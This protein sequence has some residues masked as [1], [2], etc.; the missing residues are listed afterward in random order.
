MNQNSFQALIQLIDDPDEMVFTEVRKQIS[1]IGNSAL[2]FL[3]ASKEES[4]HDLVFQKRIDSLIQDV[5]FEDTKKRFEKWLLSDERNLLEGSLIIAQ[6]HYPRLDVSDLKALL[7]TIKKAIWLELS[8][9]NTAFE[10][11]KIMNKVFF[12]HLGYHGNKINLLTPLNSYINTVLE[13]K[14]GNS[15]SLCIIYSLIAQELEM[16]LY[17]VNLPNH[18]ILAYM[19]DLHIN[20]FLGQE[21]PYGVLFYVDVFNNGQMLN[22]EAIVKYLE[23]HQIASN[24]TYFEPCSNS[25]L[26]K[27][28]LSNL[29]HSYTQ[30]GMKRKSNELQSLKEMLA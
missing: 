18:C 12:E 9:M 26:I 10:K 21:N 22:E 24:R 14:T 28:M 5:K 17:A 1:N 13:L 23:N 16:P 25:L 3:E 29:I 7:D 30:L 27:Q 20:A 2:D 6:Y 15:L 11:V 4:Y 19:D 8:P